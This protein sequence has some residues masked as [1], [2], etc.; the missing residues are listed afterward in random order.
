MFFKKDQTH[1]QLGLNTD[2]G[3]VAQGLSTEFASAESKMTIEDEVRERFIELRGP[4]FRYLLLSFGGAVEQCEEITQEVF[5]R[6]FT[7]M[8]NG[9]Q[10]RDVK[11]WVYRV[12][13]NL[14][15]N[16]IKK[17]Q[18]VLPLSDDD[19]EGLK[20]TLADNSAN[21]EQMLLRSE[22]FE[23]LRKAMSKL[24]PLE[25]EC[26]SLR[27]RGL[28]YREIGEVMDIGTTTVSDV[29]HRAISKLSGDKNG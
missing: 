26:L 14:A 15:I 24:T 9:K 27:T 13:H 22:K 5:L 20:Q 12:A 19:W 17:Q 21:P 7:E 25:R 11:A 16:Q 28:R 3:T 2:G 8:S 10:V 29:L 18:F 1:T 6:L 4:V 23:R